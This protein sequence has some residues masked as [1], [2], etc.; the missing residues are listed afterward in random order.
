MTE[1][2][3]RTKHVYKRST[4]VHSGSDKPAASKQRHYVDNQAFYN[5][6]VERRQL[7][8]EAKAA[9]LE[10]PRITNFIGECILRIATNLSNKY[11]FASYPFKEE[12]IADAIEHC[13]R[14]IDSFDP[15]KTKNPF[16]YYTQTCYYSFISRIGEEKKQL[17]TK[18][19]AL[20]SS[21]ALGEL[22]EMDVAS[23]EE[24]KHI[25]DNFEMDQDYMEKFLSDYDT[26]REAKKQN[27]KAP[28][29][30]LEEFF[31]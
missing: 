2:I 26:K 29:S 4:I 20:L 24:A 10:K 6:L 14:Y 1:S 3:D 22:A 25:F 18:F 5:A 23:D 17:A 21:A 30:P 13:L 12:M 31:E 19:K 11:Q 7:V 8:D 15:S 28:I 16:S 9:G 27:K